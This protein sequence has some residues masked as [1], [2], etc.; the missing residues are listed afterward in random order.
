MPAT[1]DAHETVKH[2]FLKISRYIRTSLY[3]VLFEVHTYIHNWS[4]QPF[5]QDYDL[6]SHTAY[7]VCIN[8]IHHWRALQFKVNSERQIF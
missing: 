7:V 2:T 6:V 3:R 8:P 1:P 4:L 5:N